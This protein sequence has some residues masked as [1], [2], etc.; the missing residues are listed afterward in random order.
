VCMAGLAAG[1]LALLTAGSDPASTS[2]GRPSTFVSVSS[3]AQMSLYS[4]TTGARIRTLARFP[5][6]K[7]TNNGL[8]Y[9]PDGSAVYFTL[10][11]R[12]RHE[13]GIRLMRLDTATGRQ[14]LIAYGEQPAI[15]ADG[16]ELAYG[17]WPSGLAV[18]E[19]A[20]GQTRTLQLPQLGRS[21][22]LVNAAI[23][24]LG[25]GTD[26]AVVPFPAPW[27]LVGVPP[28]WRWCGISQQRA[29]IVFVHVPAPPAP[30][31]ARCVHLAAQA[32]SAVNAVAPSPGSPDAVRLATD[33]LDGALEVE[34]I[35]PSGAITRTF[36][37]RSSL[38]LA[39]DPS[40][41]SLLYFTRHDPGLTEATLSGAKLM[42]GGWHRPFELGS[43]AW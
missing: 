36:T 15:S 1:C 13:P 30:L 14:T 23:G 17:A 20:T 24:W 9:A 5:P 37:F 10:V 35:A 28:P 40:G 2:A 19:L 22:S 29:V 27:D 18:R 34:Q 38:P 7:F 4:S 43:L 12:S 25:S 26:L 11:P 3:D 41:T 8:A 31:S 32:F 16:R 6:L 21:A 33:T 39:F 42:P